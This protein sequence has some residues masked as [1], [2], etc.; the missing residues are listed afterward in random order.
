MA[1]DITSEASREERK[2]VRLRPHHRAMYVHAFRRALSRLWLR[3]ILIP[4][5]GR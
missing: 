4:L 5:A 3:T 2:G 1:R